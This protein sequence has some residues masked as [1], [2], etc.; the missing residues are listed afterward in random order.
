MYLCPYVSG[1]GHIFLCFSL[2]INFLVNH[3]SPSISLL[4]FLPLFPELSLPFLLI[5]LFKVGLTASHCTLFPEI[6]KLLLPPNSE[7]SSFFMQALWL[8]LFSKVNDIWGKKKLFWPF[9]W[10]V[11]EFSRATH[12]VNPVLVYTECWYPS[13]PVRNKVVKGELELS[14]I[15]KEKTIISVK[16]EHLIKLFLNV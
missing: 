15:E 1:P 14:G 16:M 13:R 6:I 2:C 4:C 11:M 7:S 8:V 5:H 3:L 10:P 12:H 9:P